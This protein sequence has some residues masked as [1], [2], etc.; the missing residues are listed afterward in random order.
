MLLRLLAVCLESTPTMV[1][2]DLRFSELMRAD[3]RLL[4]SPLDRPSCDFGR[5]ESV[6]KAA[7]SSM[8]SSTSMGAGDDKGEGMV[9]STL[10]FGC[11]RSSYT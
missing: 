6:S 4:V 3:P 7:S 10:G 5:S 8:V 9:L 2:V 1:P 11:V